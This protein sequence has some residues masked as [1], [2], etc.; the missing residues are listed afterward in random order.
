M[1]QHDER[2]Q[3]TLEGD[4]QRCPVDAAEKSGQQ[5]EDQQSDI[6][7]VLAPMSKGGSIMAANQL[8]CY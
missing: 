1:H 4:A 7:H 6:I 2:L 5:K 3:S 8:G